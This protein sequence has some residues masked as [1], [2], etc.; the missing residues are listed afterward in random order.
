MTRSPDKDEGLQERALGF[1]ETQNGQ[2]SAVIAFSLVATAVLVLVP[3]SLLAYIFGVPLMFFVP[4]FAVVRLFFQKGTSTEARF[5]LSMGLSLLVVVLLGLALVL[6]PIGLTSDSTRASLILFALAAVA[7]ETFWLRADRAGP[8]KEPE[9]PPAPRERIDK[10]VAAMLATA[11]VVS[12][13]SLGLIVT[14]ERT[15]RTYFALTDENGMVLTNITW[16]VG[17]NITL[18]LHMKNGED[19]ERTFV[20]SAYGL[21]FYGIETQTFNK[22]LKK[23]ELWNQTVVFNLTQAGYFRLDFDLY[24]QDGDLPP[25]LY[26]N[27][28]VWIRVL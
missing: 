20:L 18:L 26:G 1:L 11:L 9:A 28:H 27:L 3:G 8:E 14:A 2:R 12:G 15:S 19:G 6:T 17:S 5:V 4:G 13:I 23:N 24:I 22:T 21:G 7:L 25:F 10:V 16:P